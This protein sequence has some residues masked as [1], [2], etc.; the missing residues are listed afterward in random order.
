MGMINRLKRVVYKVMYKE[1]YMGHEDN[2]YCINRGYKG[3]HK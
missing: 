1:I 2:I 3:S